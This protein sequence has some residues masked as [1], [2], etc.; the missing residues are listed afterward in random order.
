MNSTSTDTSLAARNGFS[1]N[2]ASSAILSPYFDR[3]AEPHL[4]FY[5]PDFD[6][7]P[8]PVTYAGQDPL[9][10][11]R[12]YRTEI[13]ECVDDER[14]SYYDYRTNRDAGYE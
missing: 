8:E 11:F 7:P 6:P 12:D 1:E 5:L 9:L 4:R 10:V 2:A 3:N 14:G 13:E